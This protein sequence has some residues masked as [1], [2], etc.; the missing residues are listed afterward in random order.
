M[1][2]MP[3]CHKGEGY[4]N[5]AHANKHSAGVEPA[6]RR[7]LCLVQRLRQEEPEEGPGAAEVRDWRAEDLAN[8]SSEHV[9]QAI[10]VFILF[11]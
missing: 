3:N 6:E 1:Q 11:I 10:G 9:G 4:E 5:S 8:L 2:R 7:A